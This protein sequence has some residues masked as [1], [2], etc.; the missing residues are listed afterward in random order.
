MRYKWVF[1]SV[2]SVLRGQ[3]QKEL[4]I[5][6]L[7]A[8]LLIQRGVYTPD[9]AVRFLNPDLNYLYPPELM[10]DMEKAV[11]IIRRAIE[12]SLRIVV[13][14]DY[15]VDGVTASALLY[16]T[17]LQ[18]GAE[19]YVFIPDRINEGYGLN[20]NGLRR[21]LE[22]LKPEL[23]ITV[24]CGIRAKEAVEYLKSLNIKVIITDHHIPSEELP[25]ADAILNP[26]IQGC[27]YPYKDLSGVGI[28]YKLAGAL[29]NDKYSFLDL[30][31]LGTVADIVPL[32]GENRIIV[33]NGLCYLEKT[34][35]VGLRALIEVVGLS[36]I[37]VRSIGYILGP[38][39][40]AA[41]RLD[42]AMRAFK[43]LTCRAEQEAIE[44]A[45]QLCQQNNNRQ[46]I[47][48]KILRDA[49][50]M[51]EGQV[52]EGNRVIVVASRDWHPGVVGIVASK[53]VEK[54]CRPAIVISINKATAKG[55]ARSV[56]GFDITSCL[57][58]CSK[59]L[60]NFGGHKLAAGLEISP[61]LIDD[62]RRAINSIDDWPISRVKGIIYV[63]G[64]LR[65][66][67]L[68]LSLI[69][70]MQEL[71]PFGEGNPPPVFLFQ[72]LYLRSDVKVMAKDTV[73]FWV[74]DGGFSLP[75]VGFGM[76]RILED[77]KYAESFDLLGVPTVSSYQGS[78]WMQLE[79]LDWRV[80]GNGSLN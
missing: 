66:D 17:L 30:T 18:M 38:K 53:L 8:H 42:S 44:I 54:F 12:D 29:L 48:D 32:K 36:R 1:S 75:V 73:K 72:N 51:A 69:E 64:R 15:D 63:D 16:E 7:I 49:M 56:E 74:T 2:D 10:R 58:K 77:L 59:Y 21:C 47:Q 24:D 39:L 23:L 80:R 9:E 67:M 61:L 45:K 22:E 4:G 3:L 40:N 31:A 76:K 71:A 33:K 68:S 5:H 19:V 20:N 46:K 28:A 52:R 34:K 62:F 37:T 55:S 27:P 50:D 65:L 25:P 6:P 11:A 60:K 79:L 78:D 43:L 26:K 14:G 57:K 35:R 13:Y 70:Q 41:G